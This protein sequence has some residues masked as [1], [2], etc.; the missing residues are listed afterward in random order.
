MLLAL[1]QADD[2][3]HNMARLIIGTLLDIGNGNRKIEDIDKI[4]ARSSRKRI[5]SI[6]AFS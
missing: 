3:L 6:Y 2:F 1:L 4:F 5:A